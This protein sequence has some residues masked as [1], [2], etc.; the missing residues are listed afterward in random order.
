MVDAMEVDGGDDDDAMEVAE[1]EEEAAPAAAPEAQQRNQQRKGGL[2]PGSRWDADEKLH[3]KW[4]FYL[5]YNDFYSYPLQFSGLT[6]DNG[7]IPN[8]S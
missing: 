6:S 1:V 3:F 7:Y 8:T 2:P 5:C 4:C